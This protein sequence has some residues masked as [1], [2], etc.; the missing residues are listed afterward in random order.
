[1]AR[2]VTRLQLV[3]RA[4]EMADLESSSFISDAQWQDA[5][6]RYLTEVYDLLV[7]SG[8]PDYYASTAT[9]TTVVGTTA[10]ALPA[11]F[12][13]SSMVYVVEDGVRRRPLNAVQDR[14]RQSFQAPTGVYTIELEYIQNPPVLTS[15]SDTFDG[16]SGWDE[17]VSALMARFALMKME[18]D[19]SGLQQVINECRARIRTCSSNRDRGGPR[20]ISD[21]DDNDQMPWWRFSVSPISGYRIRGDNLELYAPAW[22]P[23]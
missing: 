3:N 2:T 23:P 18:Q 19:A 14:L 16:V 11:D 6:N 1:M 7:Q 10:Y 5:A 15:D 21:I 4:K 13:T 20:Y 22:G 8:P 9:F 12:R 17:L